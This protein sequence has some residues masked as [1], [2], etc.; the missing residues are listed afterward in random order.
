MVLHNTY[1]NAARRAFAGIINDLGDATT[2]VNVALLDITHT[3]DLS[4]HEVFGDVSPDEVSGT[5]Y[6][7]GGA[8]IT[9]KTLT[10]A[11]LVTTFDGDDVAWTDS[12]ISAGY[13]VVYEATSG[14]LLTLVDFEGEQSSENGTFEVSWHVDG[15]FTATAN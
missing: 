14:S 8:E 15:I 3:P 2:T 1:G 12:T 9:T 6:T 10:E 11:A 5:G 13:A 4:G 7:A